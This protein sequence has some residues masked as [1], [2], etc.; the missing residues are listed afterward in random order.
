MSGRKLPTANTSQQMSGR[1]W[2]N[3]ALR[4]S[5]TAPESIEN[6]DFPEISLNHVVLRGFARDGPYLEK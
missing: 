4:P 3:L 6:H 1:W 2:P 5:Q